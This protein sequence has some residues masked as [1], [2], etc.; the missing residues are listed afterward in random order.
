MYFILGFSVISVVI[1][2]VLCRKYVQKVFDSIDKVLDG[3]LTKDADLLS[4]LSDELTG[5]NRISK[6]THKARRIM[7][8]L[9]AQ[10]EQSEQEKETIQTF[11][12]DMSHQMKTPLAG[13]SMY[14]DLLLE[15]NLSNSEQQEFLSR[16]K[17]SAEKMQW[18]MD[19]LLR[20]SRLEVGAIQLVTCAQN[21][22][23]TISEAIGDVVGIAVRKN[24]SIAVSESAELDTLSLQHDRKWTREVIAN[25]LENA[26]KYSADGGEINITFEQMPVYTKVI[27]TDNGIGIDKSDWNLIFKRFYRGQNVKENLNLSGYNNNTGAGLGLYLAAL[28]MEKQGGYIMVDSVPGEF[29]SFSLFL[30]N[31]KN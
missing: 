26:V 28:I 10:I 12:S 27:I 4:G 2:V 15:G 18:L 30:Q 29:T 17:Q 22:K 9:R 8:M 7:L 11:I 3:V 6:L 24:I 25:I 16:M 20:A 14:A 23:Q 5:E 1:T 19:A 21:I 13:I 31:C